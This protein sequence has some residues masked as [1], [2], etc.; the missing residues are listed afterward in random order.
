MVSYE[1]RPNQVFDPKKHILGVIAM[2]YLEQATGDVHHLVPA[3]VIADGNYLYHSIVLLM[4][5]PVVTWGELR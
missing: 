2:Q 5:N 1:F 4:N 3:D